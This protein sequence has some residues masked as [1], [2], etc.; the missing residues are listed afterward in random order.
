[1]LLV[2]ATA[3]AQLTGTVVAAESREPL[4]LSVVSLRPKFGQRFTDA[5]GRFAF[6]PTPAGTYVLSVRQIGYAPLDTQ[7]VT[8]GD[9]THLQIALR[10]LA[11]ELPPVTIAGSQCTNPGPPD[12]RDT[13]LRAVFDQLQENARRLALLADSYPFRYTLELAD[14]AVSQ[15]GDT[16]P[17]ATRRLQFSSGD[18]RRHPN[19]VGRVVQRSWGP[20]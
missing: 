17:P 11:I 19:A 16:G 20:W 1:M 15:R 4:G 18:K 3:F 8:T 2:F 5:G 6:A 13:A 9:S 10:R 12:S 7:L 14:R